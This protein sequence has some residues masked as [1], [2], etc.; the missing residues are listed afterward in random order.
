MMNQRSN[1]RDF[2]KK[3][4]LAGFGMLLSGSSLVQ[5]GKAPSEK[6]HIGC[7]G[8]Q[9]RA[10]SHIGGVRGQNIVAI[11]DVD[12]N[13][14]NR[15]HRDFPKANKYNDYRKLVDQKDIEAIVVS[16][17]DHMHA[18]ATGAALRSGRH[19]YC[20]K[21][22][23]HTVHEARVIA[24]LAKEH[25]RATQLGTQIHAGGNYRRV[26]EIIQS[27]AIGEVTESHVWVGKS[28]N[29]GDRPAPA[30]VPVDRPAPAVVVAVVP[31][32]V[33][34]VAVGN[35]TSRPCVSRGTIR[36]ERS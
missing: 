34:P 22:L 18:P 21:P 17:P 15:R 19:A 24:G 23:T 36:H 33:G 16:T 29:A 9:N 25:K 13:Y 7:V 1:R 30:P 32:P 10:S 20:E 3:G 4:S 2:L 27:G 26:V 12:Q 31:A 28:W 8:P 5:A 11:C 35:T 6:L 14:L